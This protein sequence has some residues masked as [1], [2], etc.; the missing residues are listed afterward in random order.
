[1]RIIKVQ[2]LGW[3]LSPPCFL[4]S[5]HVSFLI[6]QDPLHVILKPLLVLRNGVYVLR[7]NNAFRH[8]TAWPRF[9]DPTQDL[10]GEHHGIGGT[11]IIRNSLTFSKLPWDTTSGRVWAVTKMCH[12]STTYWMLVSLR[13]PITS[14]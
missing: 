9:T 6:P 12:H 10:I 1:M 13:W 11:L 3:S 7:R 2:I 8:P 14:I 4:T 5:P